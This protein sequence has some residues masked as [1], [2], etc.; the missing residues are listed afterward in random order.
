MNV[1]VVVK[2]NGGVINCPDA[3]GADDRVFKM[4]DIN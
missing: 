2:G 1:Q 3:K 4:D